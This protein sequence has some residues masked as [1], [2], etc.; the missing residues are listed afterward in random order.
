MEYICKYCGR[1]CKSMNSLTQ[2]EIRCKQNPERIICYG[3]KANMPKRIDRVL[4]AK[5]VIYGDTLD[6]TNRELE[7]YRETHLTC[8]ICGKTIEES[9]KSNSKFAAKKLCV[10][11]DH[12]TLKFRGLLCSRCNRQLGWFENH[13]NE[14]LQYLDKANNVL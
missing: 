6:I 12:K 8:E 13:R 10:D 14:I 2:H 11:H 1:L 3:N 9:I 5:V 4:N 7:E